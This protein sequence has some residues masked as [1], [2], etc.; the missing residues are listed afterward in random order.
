MGSARNLNWRPG[1][2]VPVAERLR[3]LQIW[4][5]SVL[6]GAVLAAASFRQLSI[7]DRAPVVVGTL[8]FVA[9]GFALTRLSTRTNR[10]GRALLRALLLGDA[11]AVVALSLGISGPNSPL[12][13]LLILQVVEV[14]LLA[15]FRTGLKLA[16]WQ[17]MLISSMYVIG[18]VVAPHLSTTHLAPTDRLDLQVLVAMTW[19]AAITTAW[20]AAANERELRR[21]RYDLERLARF[22][23]D[24]EHASTSEAAAGVFVELAADE[25]DAT[26]AVVLMPST[27]SDVLQVLAAHGLALDETP[28][29]DSADS[30]INEATRSARTLLVTGLDARRD[31]A[32][33]ALL[34]HASNLAV[35]PLRTERGKGVLVVEYGPVRASRVERRV[36]S[37]LERY[38]DELGA[39]LSQLWLIDSLRQAATIDPL[40]GVANRARLRESLRELT[41]HATRTGQPLSLLMLDVDHFKRVNDTHGHAAGDDVLRQVASVLKGTVRPYDVVA[42][43][44]G[45]EFVVILPGAELHDAIVVAERVRS[46]LPAA[47]VPYSVTASFGATRFD[48]AVDDVDNVIKRADALLYDAKRGGRNRIVASD[49]AP[50]APLLPLP[51]PQPDAPRA[52]APP[53]SPLSP[54]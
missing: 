45:E 46:A 10:A 29:N 15:S 40:T 31:H 8:I 44:G 32:L 1:D 11:V 20:L 51:A 17:S 49:V 26:R 14:S 47:T 37:M 50:A 48:P 24:I 54:P 33:T 30:L 19:V 16:A 25:L 6:V 35:L 42:R 21:R 43:Y 22:H 27:D 28:I 36:V 34:P 12:R 5:M 13:Y 3:N 38:R 4:R 9:V 53:R 39:R 7:V 23:E 52:V 41:Q 2:L 18:P